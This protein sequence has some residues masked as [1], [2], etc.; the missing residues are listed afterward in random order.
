MAAGAKGLFPEWKTRNFF[1]V[2]GY[3]SR[4]YTGL[5]ANSAPP[6]TSRRPEGGV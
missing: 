6:W 5:R 3:F 4:Y 1:L 2:A